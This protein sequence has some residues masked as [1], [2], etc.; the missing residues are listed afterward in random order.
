V[1]RRRSPKQADIADPAPR[2]PAVCF[3]LCGGSRWPASMWWSTNAGI[4]ASG[5]RSPR[6]R[7]P[8][9]VSNRHIAKKKSTSR[10]CSHV[11]PKPSLGLLTVRPPFINILVERDHTAPAHLWR[12]MPPTK[13]RSEANDQRAHQKNCA[14]RNY[15]RQPRFTPGPIAHRAVSLNASRRR[16]FDPPDQGCPARNGSASP[17]DISAV[18]RLP[19]F[20][21][22]RAVRLAQRP[23]TLGR[24]NW[25]DP[26]ELFH[27]SLNQP[28][29]IE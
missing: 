13:A 16:W 8:A 29:H 9:A 25:R 21:R 4:K 3:R 5:D 22:P 17:K 20:G 18:V 7:P 2:R 6:A 14:A 1:A 12:L 28:F 27:S 15:H 23:G 19:P 24:A 11:A 26:S 10:A